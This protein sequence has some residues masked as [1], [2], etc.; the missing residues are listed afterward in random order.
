MIDP[1][2]DERDRMEWRGLANEND[3]SFRDSSTEVKVVAGRR[4]FGIGGEDGRG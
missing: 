1:G 4:A 2:D 3:V